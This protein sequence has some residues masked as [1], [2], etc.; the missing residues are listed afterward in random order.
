MSGKASKSYYARVLG[1]FWRHP[2]TAAL[3]LA[4]CG[5]W[6]R[7]LSWSADHRTDGV[8]PRAV[9]PM[10]LGGREDRRAIAELV[11]A[12]L[13][14]EAGDALQVRDWDQHNITKEQHE[15]KLE[16]VRKRVT[17]ARGNTSTDTP[18]TESVTRYTERTEH[19]GTPIPSDQDQDQDQLRSSSA[20]R[21]RVREGPVRLPA[22]ESDPIESALRTGYARRYEHEVR[23]AWLTHARDDAELRRVAMWCR[24]QPRPHEAA[25]RFLDG[26][27]GG[28]AP[29]S[30][31][32][33]RWPWKWLA[34]DP[35]RTAGLSTIPV[36]AMGEHTSL[37]AAAAAAMAAIPTMDMTPR[38]GE[39]W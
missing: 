5:A 33:N 18:V 6:V 28:G 31:R 11:T 30:W 12:G 37:D 23:D 39:T 25:E 34:E 17:K 8:I 19:E 14:V 22:P 4:A 24:A 36:G 35:G 16:A 7:C 2:R 20:S 38:E 13:L 9:V 21:A 1:T 15:Q 27:F 10:V 3:S 32:K 29:S 26:A